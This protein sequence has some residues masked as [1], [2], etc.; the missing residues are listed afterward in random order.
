MKNLIQPGD[1]L[2]KL[3]LKD[4]YL[5]VPIYQP[6]RCFLR[7]QWQGVMWQF[8]V[9]PF[10]MSSA[11]YT[12]TKIMKPEVS[13]LRR[14]GI[15]LI[16]YL[17]DMQLLDQSKERIRHHF[18]SALKLLVALGFLVNLKKSVLS[19]EIGIPRIHHGLYQDGHISPKT[20]NALN[21]SIGQQSSGQGQGGSERTG[22]DSGHNGCSSPSCPPSPI[23][24][25]LS[26]EGQIL[27][28]QTGPSIPST[29]GNYTRYEG[30]PQL[31]DL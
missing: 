21:H 4:A 15:R 11:P 16:L 29:G 22:E 12:F 13:A 24:L 26:A 27:S 2:I 9:L 23:P 30:R 3:D 14:L 17:D 8:K 1:W 7:L 18:A 20:Q 31:L 10:G 25:P 28:P 6:H 5:A 19:Q